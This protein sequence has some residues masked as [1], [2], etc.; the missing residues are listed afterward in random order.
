MMRLKDQLLRK[1]H[2]IAEKYT[3]KEDLVKVCNVQIDES[4]QKL[5]LSMKRWHRIVID[6]EKKSFF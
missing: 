5:F 6:K 4:E 3:N 2:L 1:V